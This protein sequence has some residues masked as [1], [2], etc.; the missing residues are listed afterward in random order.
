MTDWNTLLMQDLSN[1]RCP[2]LSRYTI[3]DK[4]EYELY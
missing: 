2:L 4:K 1:D 3:L